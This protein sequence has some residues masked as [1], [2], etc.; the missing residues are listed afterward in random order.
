M[1]ATATSNEIL[2][3]LDPREFAAIERVTQDVPLARAQVLAEAGEP[4]QYVYFPTEGVLSLVGGTAG[5]GTVEVAIVGSEGVASISA[6]LGQQW[7]PFRVV[8][9]IPGHALRVPTQ[10]VAAMVRDCGHFHERL[11]A[12]THYMLAQVAQSAVCNRF[13]NA[14]QRLARW[15]LMTADRSGAR[16]LPLTHEFISYMVGGPRSAVSEAASELRESG[17][18]EYR[19]GLITVRDTERLREMACECYR[20]LAYPAEVA[21][22]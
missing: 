5:G 17:A 19:R 1:I 9:Q 22:S 2:N 6:V 16:A 4:A 15:L 12:Y 18:I 11:L 7:L 3:G 14:Q 13:H 8:T 10:I 21:A 20:I